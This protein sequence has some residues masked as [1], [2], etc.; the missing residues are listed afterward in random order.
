MKQRVL[1]VI[2][3]LGSLYICFAIG[4]ALGK[5]QSGEATSKDLAKPFFLAT[6]YSA[7]LSLKTEIDNHTFIK[8]GNMF[9]AEQFSLDRI[10]ITIKQIEGID[11]KNSM[12]E[13]EINQRVAEA[14]TYVR[15]ARKPN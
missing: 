13:A 1:L 11:Y 15:S 6:A 2:I 8:S 4:H 10:E 5:R 3:F 14:K 7:S 9:V 12:F